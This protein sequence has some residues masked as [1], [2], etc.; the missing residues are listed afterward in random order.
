[1][2]FVLLL[3]FQAVVIAV[4]DD[5][6]N[7][8][9]IDHNNNVFNLVNNHRKPVTLRFSL[10]GAKIQNMS[11]SSSTVFSSIHI[12]LSDN[13]TIEIEQ[14]HQQQQM[15]VTEYQF[16]WKTGAPSFNREICF[17]YGFNGASW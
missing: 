6:T 1:M 14:Q 9:K 10:N 5:L 4:S 13:T 7:H 8:L 17:H 16:V 11:L 15:N 3:H 12:E 2:F